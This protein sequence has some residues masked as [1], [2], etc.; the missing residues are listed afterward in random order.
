M[1]GFLQRPT[2]ESTRAPRRGLW[3]PVLFG[4][5][6]LPT[7]PLLTSCVPAHAKVRQVQVQPDVVQAS[8]RFRKEY[9]L[10]PGDQIDVTLRRVPELSRTVVIR[11]DGLISLPI[12]QDVPAKG[13][14]PRELSVKLR[15][16]YSARL[17]DPEVNVI[18]TQV[19]QLVVYVVGEVNNVI[20]VPFREA[21]TA[22]QA[23]AL[24]GGFR[25][26]ASP[27]DV[28]IIRLSEDGVLQAITVTSNDQGQ[29]GP[30]I[31]LR[32]TTLQPDDIVFV[33]ESGR[34]QIARFL[35]D[36]VNRPIGAINALLGTYVNIRFLEILVK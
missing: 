12:L 9:V 31:A 30:Y 33:P 3:R 32:G 6:V 36:F 27:S 34:N 7:L 28:T 23:I 14:T 2:V 4:L 29:P 10:V 20:A 15:E 22:M 24:A 5:C 18:P 21:P 1:R 25:R 35:D 16:L 8:V 19:R 13:L 11:P 17:V 26:S